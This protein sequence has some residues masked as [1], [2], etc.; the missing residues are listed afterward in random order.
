ME[1]SEITDEMIEKKYFNINPVGNLSV[2]IRTVRHKLENASEF[3]V[4]GKDLTLDILADKYMRYVEYHKKKYGT[5]E[6]YIPK[7]E[8]LADP[9]EYIEKNM[10]Y[11][12]YGKSRDSRDRYLFG[13]MT[14]DELRNSL[15]KFLSSYDITP[16][17][18]VNKQT[19]TVIS[20]NN[21]NKKET[22]EES[23]D[24]SIKPSKF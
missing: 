17:K 18:D 11:T 12:T 19:T 7:T 3:K 21:G 15:N 22:N 23:F 14:E 2:I 4:E 9:Y 8:K 5:D 24:F 20:N 13:D 10:F 16:K 1:I 6:K